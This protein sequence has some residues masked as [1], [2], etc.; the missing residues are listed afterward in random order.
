[1]VQYFLFGTFLEKYR[2]KHRGTFIFKYRIPVP[3]VLKKMVF[4]TRCTQLLGNTTS[5]TKI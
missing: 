4:A 2:Q 1:M 5:I 3:A